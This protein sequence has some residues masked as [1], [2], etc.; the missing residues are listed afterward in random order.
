VSRIVVSLAAIIRAAIDAEP[1]GSDEAVLERPVGILF[2]D[3]DNLNQWE[4]LDFR[5]ACN[6]VLHADHVEPETKPDLGGGTGS[7][8][9]RFTVYGRLGKKEWRAEL[10][11]KEYALSAVALVP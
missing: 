11:L 5:T 2:P 6:K 10:Y 8:T 4:P 3:K 7:L 1:L 9:G